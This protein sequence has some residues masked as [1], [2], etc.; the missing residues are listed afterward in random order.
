MTPLDTQSELNEIESA[1]SLLA[2]AEALGFVESDEMQRLRGEIKD[3]LSRGAEACANA[4]GEYEVAAERAHLTDTDEG[5]IGLMLMKALMYQESGLKDAYEEEIEDTLNCAEGLSTS[6][7]E[8]FQPIV[9][10]IRRLK[11]G[12]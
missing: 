9:E 8:R 12:E 10:V 2:L 7:P 4:W 1:S 5:R 6:F 3:L 11:T